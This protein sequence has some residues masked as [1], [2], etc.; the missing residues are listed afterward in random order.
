MDQSD[1]Y[2][3]GSSRRQLRPRKSDVKAVIAPVEP[4]T[5]REE[6]E[7]TK[8]ISKRSRIESSEESEADVESKASSDESDTASEEYDAQESNARNASVVIPMATPNNH[9][10]T[11][12]AI[13]SA[14]SFADD[15][16]LIFPVFPTTPRL[17]QRGATKKPKVPKKEFAEI[18]PEMKDIW[19]KIESQQVISIATTLQPENV[20]V[21][22]LPFQLEGLNW[23]IKQ[24]ESIYKGGILADEM[25]MGKTI[26]MISLLVS[27]QSDKVTL[28]ICPT[29]AMVHNLLIEAS[30]DF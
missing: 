29:V 22:L 9:T 28:I 15:D 21:K 10:P 7:A 12:D 4:D 23:L 11:T 14:I 17:P 27:N 19:E 30:V 5:E 3:D 8:K 18:H 16:D 13:S 25:G 20:R 6:E 24:E 1:Y 26:Q 2:Q